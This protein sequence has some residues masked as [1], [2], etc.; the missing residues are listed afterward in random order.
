MP[1]DPQTGH[2][3]KNPTHDFA[4]SDG[5]VSYGFKF[6]DGVP[7]RSLTDMG[8]TPSTLKLSGG[9]GKYGDWDPSMSHIEQR[10][11]IGGRG[12]ED[13]SD[14]PTRFFDSRMA[15]TLTESWLYP[16]PKWKFA[17]GLVD[18]ICEMPGDISWVGLFGSDQYTSVSFSFSSETDVDR[19]Y[20]WIRRVGKPGTL[21]VAL[22]SDSGGDPDSSIA[23]TTVTTDTITDVVS[24]LHGFV[25]GTQTCAAST[26]YHIVVS[27]A[28]TD[29]GIN[30]WEIATDSDGAG[31]KSSTDGSS[32]SAAAYTFYHRVM[33]LGVQRKFH[34]FFMYGQWYVVDE[35]DDQTASKIYMNGWRGKATSATSTVI[36][37]TNASMTVDRLIGATVKII[38]GTGKGQSRPITDNDATTITVSPAFD[39]TPDNT[40]VY[41]VLGSPWWFELDTTGIT[42]VVTSV[43]VYDDIA[44]FAQGTS[45]NMR[46]MRFN[47]GASPPAHEYGDDGTNKADIIYTFYDSG[48]KI[49]K[50]NNTTVKEDSAAGTAWGTNLTFSGT[51]TAIGDSTYVVNALSDY[52][53]VLWAMKEDS[54]W[55]KTS[56]GW[57]KL[58]V[59]LEALPSSNNGLAVAAQ[60]MYFFFSWALSVERLYGGATSNSGTLDD[61]GPWKGSGMPEGRRGVV[62]A[63][64]PIIGWLFG[65]ID[66]GR[67]STSSVLIY[68]GKG[69]HEVFRAWEAGRRIRSLFWAPVPESQPF[70]WISCGEDL[71]YQRYPNDSLNLLQDSDIEFQHEAVVVS[72]M[73]DMGAAR[74]PKFF[75]ELTLQT[76]NQSNEIEVQLDYQVDAEIGTSTW[77]SVGEF[78]TSP[79]DTL[80]IRQGNKRRV[81]TRMRMRTDDADKP[82]KI[83]ATVLEGYA[84]TPEKRQWNMV[85]NAS[86]Y[87]VNKRGGQE[88]KPG[89]VYRWLLKKLR[90]ADGLK[91]TSGV[92]EMDE[93][94]VVIDNVVPVRRTID[95]ITGNWSGYIQLTVR[96]A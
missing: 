19:A 63:L 54:V 44:I 43:C 25:F 10:S 68:N 35:R 36:T 45:I 56:D 55:R 69:W 82:P 92:E 93:M 28:A 60:N 24:E 12:G 83:R 16:A 94:D 49:Y 62:S 52:D 38:S 79:E 22:Y 70:L 57:L 41:V 50:V 75:K 47:D 89:E 9:G 15:W 3:L 42:G 66:A 81:V 96:E 33:E 46:K 20:L 74:I 34:P 73:V 13:F 53:E 17:R 4:L 7:E 67:N 5:R 64:L 1:S 85:V 23:S 65:S 48:V 61:V 84:R 40:S 71:V 6:K 37:N 72:S 95:W 58:N 26:T 14:D 88:P 86:S 51:E 87:G 29:S 27:A 78:L 30:H 91:L 80:S 21:T 18:D 90:Q 8:Q 32:W 31:S 77:N 59:G 76:N 11:W 39:K 2:G